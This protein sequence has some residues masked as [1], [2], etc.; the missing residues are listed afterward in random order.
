M[1]RV[2]YVHGDVC[3]LHHSYTYV[4]AQHQVS[5]EHLDFVQQCSGDI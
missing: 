1:C 3:R 5:S 4:L 2:V